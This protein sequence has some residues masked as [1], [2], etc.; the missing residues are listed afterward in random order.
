M[1]LLIIYLID[2]GIIRFWI[3]NFKWFCKNFIFFNY[4]KIFW[5]KNGMLWINLMKIERER[6]RVI[7]LYVK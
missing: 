5:K 2:E 6:E 3:V 7:Y 4:K 1:L